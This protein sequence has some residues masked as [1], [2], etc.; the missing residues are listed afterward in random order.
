[1]IRLAVFA[2]VLLVAGCSATP[3]SPA[4]FQSD[5]LDALTVA[6]EDTGAH[7][8]RD[9]WAHWSSLGQGCDTREAVLK[10]QGRG[11]STGK[12]CHLLSGSW[13]SW[14]DNQ[15][16]CIA[17]HGRWETG[18]CLID[19]PDVLDVDHVV[20]LA[21]ANRSGARTWTADRRERYANDP[22]GL[23]VV[24]ASSNRSKGDKDP[25][26]WLPA[27]LGYRCEYTSRW[28]GVKTRWGLTVDRAER[29]ALAAVLG[30]CG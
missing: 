21:E 5:S 9:A 18:G 27:N 10:T 8:D 2:A 30:G 22:D 14:Y 25:A 17:I 11:T 29:D 19:D 24:S 7:Y 3:A 23:L 28:V 12:G 16:S 26:E 20:A 15:D 4:G 6:A 13:V 1:M